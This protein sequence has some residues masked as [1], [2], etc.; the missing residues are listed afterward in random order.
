MTNNG[1]LSLLEQ[2][3]AHA[4]SQG[5]TLPVFSDAARELQRAGNSDAY[6]IGTIERA[7][8]SDAALAAEVLRAA[9]SA[10]FGGLVEVTTMRAAI[11]RLGFRQVTNLAFMATEK[12]KYT[13]RQP[14][15]GA[16]MRTL[17]QH[18]SACALASQWLANRLR[19][20]Q[21]AEEAFIGGLLHDVGKLFL[22]RVLDDMTSRNPAATDSIRLADE[23]LRDAHSAVGYDLLRSW[24]LPSIYLTI[25]RDHHAEDID[26]TNVPLL[27]V[28]LA[29]QACHCVGIGFECDRSIVLSATAEAAALGLGEVALAELEVILEDVHATAA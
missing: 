13:A 1:S 3:K 14:A 27:I 26:A 8:E 15:I 28:R 4:A 19:F 25:V 10:F 17:W 29:N 11:M 9:N 5:I 12:N 20:T 23:V 22:L 18:T 24:N 6:D 2:L 21:L 16:M 7:I